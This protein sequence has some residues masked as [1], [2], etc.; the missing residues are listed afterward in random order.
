[1]NVKCQLALDKQHLHVG[2]VKILLI[3]LF[4]FQLKLIL[5]ISPH[6]SGFLEALVVK[7]HFPRP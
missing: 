4:I 6:D 1:M 7:P 3:M 2:C 5:F